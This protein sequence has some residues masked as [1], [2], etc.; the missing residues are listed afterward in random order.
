MADRRAADDAELGAQRLRL[1]DPPIRS[2][3]VAVFPALAFGA[4][5][6]WPWI[7]RFATGDRADHHLLDRP[8]DAPWR[9]A[10][11]AAFFTWVLVPFVAGSAD[12]L[13]VGLDIPYEGQ[14][15]VLRLLWLLLPAV[16]FGVTLRWMR[17]ARRRAPARVL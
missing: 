1:H 6:A 15:L 2:S 10:C 7:E 9:T 13:F 17:G 4:L 8:H 14:I 11:G 16:V 5:F 12:R 3:E